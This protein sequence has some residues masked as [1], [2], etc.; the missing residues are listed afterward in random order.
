MQ[1]EYNALSMAM[2]DVLPLQELFRTAEGALGIS[3]NHLTTFKTTAH[4][5]NQ[6]AEKLANLDPVRNSLRSKQYGVRTHWFR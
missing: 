5:D 3:K 1:A 4:E 6:E 2:K